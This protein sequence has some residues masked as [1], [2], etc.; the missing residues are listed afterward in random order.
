[1]ADNTTIQDEQSAFVP[2]D[3]IMGKTP[4]VEPV[5]EKQIGIDTDDKFYKNIIQAGINNQLDMS[6]LDSFLTTARSRDQVYSLIDDMS[7]DSTI[8]AVLETYAE[9]A[10][11]VNEN[12][13][14]MWA[15][16][17]DPDVAKFVNYLIKAMRVNKNIY[18]WVHSLCKYGDLYLRLYRESDYEDDR[19]F[20]ATPKTKLNEDVHLSDN[21]LDPDL[22]NN[23]L[24]ESVKIK[25]YSKN[26]HYVPYLEMVSNPAEMFELTKFGK[27]YAYIK[28]EV[29]S[30][31]SGN[32]D[33]FQGSEF[34]NYKFNRNDIKVYQATEFVHAY[35]EDNTDR[36]PEE[37]SITFDNDTDN[38]AEVTT[39]TYKVRR[40]QSLLY[41]VFKIWRQLQLLENSILLNRVTKSAIVRIIGVEVGDM[42]KESVAAHLQG[43][44][45]LIEQ[46]SALN[47]NKSMNEY[48]NP[49]PVENN[50][51]IP[52][53]GGVGA[54]SLQTLGGDVNVGELTDLDYFRRKL[55]GALRV[56]CL[57]GNTKILLLNG[58]T[59][60]IEEMFNNQN[61]YV[62]KGIL[63]CASNGELRPTYITNVTL[64]KQHASFIR[65]HLDNG[66]YVD[67]TP[68]HLMM[69][70]DG[71]FIRADELSIGDSLMPY[72]DKIVKGRRYVL[73]NRSGKYKLQ[74]RIVA[75][76]MGDIPN[77]Y[78]V[79]HKDRIK[80]NDDF[81]NLVTLSTEE[82]FREH[83]SELLEARRQQSV[84]RKENDIPHGNVGKIG[85]NNGIENRWVDS[86]DEIPKGFV[87][88]H[89]HTISDET[90]HNM[91]E[92]RKE[93]IKN[94]EK[95][96]GGSHWNIGEYPQSVRDKVSLSRKEL[97]A[98]MTEEEREAYHNKYSAI[99]KN[100]FSREDVKQKI[101]AHI[102][103]ERRK[104]ER[105]LRCP[106]CGSLF[107]KSM[108]NEEYQKYL[109]KE[110]IYCCNK[111]C[112]N[113]IF[114]GGKLSRS[115]NLLSDSNFDFE[116][117][118]DNRIN[119]EKRR[120]SYYCSEKL[121]SIYDEYLSDYEPNVN[122]KVINIEYLD[123]D[124]PAYD[125]GVADDCHT[126][127]LPCGIFVHNCQYFG[128][129]DD[130]AG[131]SGGQSLAIISSRYAKMVVRIQNTITQAVT[132]V[133]NL[134]L[135][136]RDL[137]GYIN[138]FTI[139]MKKPVTQDDI[140]RRDNMTGNLQVISDIMNLLG[141]SIEDNATKL[142]IEKSL[143]SP[144]L[145]NPEV[146]DYI[147][148]VIDSL[149]S[150]EET[151]ED[152]DS[153]NPPLD[154][155]SEEGGSSLAADLGLGDLGGEETATEET[156]ETEAL[157][158]PNELGLDFTDSEQEE[159]Q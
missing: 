101:H 107:K 52:S 159:F 125:I 102:P 132:D 16:S 77:G 38:E 82:H 134:M 71:S 1:M 91:S 66:C 41:N 89:I 84:Y 138:K 145:S 14:I 139:K 59:V 58:S 88:G 30:P 32:R 143:L 124:E 68:N 4:K 153:S 17:S 148:Q 39:N 133:V 3:N 12:G 154:L 31:V 76:S 22:N 50:I 51:Y 19:L 95:S 141:D 96:F 81:S 120:D 83:E 2:D 65:I 57:R 55:F 34:I 10:T 140:D 56:P 43:I 98:N 100:T 128:F 37:V 23:T 75:E 103:Q 94:S 97:F 118:E 131:F 13:D 146:L 25:A 42:P 137:T 80:I 44:K 93:A 54:L 78:Q 123:V 6:A 26:D 127:A 105:L 114:G 8:A 130:N 33:W 49:G 86:Y 122:H 36:V 106:V 149:E 53:H 28:S 15:D 62:G 46:K 69:L 136:D 73:D 110:H 45:S 151:T 35:L 113:K 92:K 87:R 29:N 24:L 40:G 47:A 85:I 20:E 74:Y 135:I 11:E 144:Y 104:V 158:T 60:T 109:D 9:D 90:R 152:E 63:G 142:K 67:V 70:R 147:Q 126:F 27:T 115:Y 111:D 79:H 150:P 112:G 21:D 155:G 18:G 72:Y 117:Y 5:P 61:K 156:G 99:A 48:T 129:T 119:G 7:E 64:T 157:P 108:N 121:K 116:Q